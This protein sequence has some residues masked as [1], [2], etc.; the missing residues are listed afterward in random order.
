[1]NTSNLNIYPLNVENLQALLD[2]YYPSLQPGNVNQLWAEIKG[3]DITLIDLE[4]AS[5]KILPFVSFIIEKLKGRAAQTNMLGYAVEIFLTG[6]IDYHYLSTERIEIIKA[7][8]AK[9]G[10]DQ[11]Y[12]EMPGKETRLFFYNNWN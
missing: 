8:R 6:D 7:V 10:M 11:T 1:M 9:A 4:Y 2:Y 12:D 5:E 3:T